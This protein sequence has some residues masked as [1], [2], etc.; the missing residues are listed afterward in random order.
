MWGIDLN[1]LLASSYSVFLVSVAG[2][3]ELV[4]RH[5]H[6]RTERSHTIGFSYHA[7][8]DFW[9]CPNGNHLFRAEITRESTAVLYRA[10]AHHCNSCPIKSRCTDS[11]EGR[12]I[13]VRSDSWLQSELRRFHRGLSLTL[14]LLADM[15]V[16]VAML[17]QNTIRDGMLLVLLFLCITGVGL[18]LSPRFFRPARKNISISS[19]HY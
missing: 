5:T 7:D 17:R 13:E 10:Q 19:V 12:T 6:R 3:L 15:I 9:K 11:D 18:R 2:V 8:L 1:V 14:L 16:A 4:A